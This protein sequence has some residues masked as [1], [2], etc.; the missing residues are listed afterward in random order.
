[1]G[2]NTFLPAQ[3]KIRGSCCESPA[4]NLLLG[5]ADRQG[6]KQKKISDLITADAGVRWCSGELRVGETP[7]SHSMS[8]LL[9]P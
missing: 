4:L 3:G 9:F 1:M 8:I 7:L 5:G 2:W 6:N